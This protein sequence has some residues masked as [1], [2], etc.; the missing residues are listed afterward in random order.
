MSLPERTLLV[1]EMLMLLFVV[2]RIRLLNI[3]NS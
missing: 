1:F 3:K 2:Q